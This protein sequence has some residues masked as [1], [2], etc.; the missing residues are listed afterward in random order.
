MAAKSKR[1]FGLSSADV[2]ELKAEFQK[3]KHL[4][5]PYRSGAYGFSVEALVALGANKPHPLAKVHAA[6]KKAAGVEWYSAWAKRE[7]R[8]AETGQDAAGRFVQ[9]LRVL[10]R[11]KDF[12][13]KLLEVGKK[14]MGSKG[15]V[16]DISRDPKGELLVALNTNSNSP[17][18]PGRKAESKTVARTAPKA[19]GK[20]QGERKGKR[21]GKHAAK[22]AKAGTA[23]PATAESSPGIE[24]TAEGSVTV[25]T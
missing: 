21:K 14:V 9:N 16:I 17:I 3:S 6:F 4:P 5:N 25:G 7:K 15:A 24:K 13:R 19:A 11:T 20:S 18:K 8:N 22:S 23:A 2:A 1:S 10:Q 12:G